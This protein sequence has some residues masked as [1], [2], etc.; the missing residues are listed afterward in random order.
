MTERIYLFS[1][2]F[3]YF[4]VGLSG[5]KVYGVQKLWG[6]QGPRIVP[7]V[8]FSFHTMDV[9]CFY[10]VLIIH[11]VEMYFKVSFWVLFSFDMFIVNC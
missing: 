3:K 6:R 11:N 5:T 2:L 7:I 8:P 4:Q 1:S 9:W 10:V